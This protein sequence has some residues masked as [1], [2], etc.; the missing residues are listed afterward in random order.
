MTAQELIAKVL[1]LEEGVCHSC[2]QHKYLAA[3][4]NLARMLQKAIELRDRYAE[5]LFLGEYRK[6]FSTLSEGDDAELDRIAKGEE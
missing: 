4:K 1:E 6:G 2:R 3:A 5:R